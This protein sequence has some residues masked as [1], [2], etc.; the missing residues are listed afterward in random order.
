MAHPEDL[1]EQ[2]NQ[3]GI[4]FLLTELET[5]LVFLNVAETTRSEEAATRN[6]GNARV[7]YESVLRYQGRVHFE[8]HEKVPFDDKV[9]LVKQG[10]VAAGFAV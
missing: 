3:A 6:R 5:A 2:S 10:L 8:K 7:A 4:G 1:L 9:A